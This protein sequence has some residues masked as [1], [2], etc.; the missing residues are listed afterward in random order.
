[1]RPPRILLLAV[2]YFVS[3]FFAITALEPMLAIPF[4]WFAVLLAMIAYLLLDSI[5]I[6]RAGIL[7]GI[8]IVLPFSCLFAGVVWWLMRW[9]GVWTPF[10]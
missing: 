10:R 5:G 4:A 1:M 7:L 3:V 2:F 6:E 8:L 9:A